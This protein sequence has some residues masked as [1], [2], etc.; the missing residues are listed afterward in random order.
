MKYINTFLI[1]ALLLCLCSCNN[2]ATPTDT[3]ISKIEVKY[4]EVL[5]YL[6][7]FDESSVELVVTYNNGT[8]KNY[9]SKDLI[10]DYT[11][12]QLL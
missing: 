3:T 1:G 12:S 6:D 9:K 4:L 10:F 7:S 8:Q 5:E 11:N 2:S